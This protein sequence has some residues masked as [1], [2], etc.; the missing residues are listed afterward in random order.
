MVGCILIELLTNDYLFAGSNETDQLNMIFKVF[1]TPNE[2]MWPGKFIIVT[3][4]YV[5]TY[6]DD[7]NNYPA[8]VGIGRVRETTSCARSV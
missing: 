7:R 1:G 3:C 6:F 4:N 5:T 2:R 8:W